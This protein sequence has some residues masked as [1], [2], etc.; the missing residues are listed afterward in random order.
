MN[1]EKNEP[2]EYID[3]PSNFYLHDDVKTRKRI[4]V[5]G[6]S[7][8]PAIPIEYYKPTAICEKCKSCHSSNEHST[9]CR[10]T[11]LISILDSASTDIIIPTLFVAQFIDITKKIMNTPEYAPIYT[12]LKLLQKAYPMFN[13]FNIL[14]ICKDTAGIGNV[15]KL[16]CQAREG[17][18]G[19]YFDINTVFDGNDL[20]PIMQFDICTYRVIIGGDGSA[21][22]W[23]TSTYV[24]N[25]L[26]AVCSED[27]LYM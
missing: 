25:V 4:F 17:H 6:F 11:Y 13:I 5:C 21:F 19:F 15:I 26:E 12:N 24:R 23:F 10:A 20:R 2:K 14:F 27:G 7:E 8:T 16:Q 18:D 22:A 3:I 1:F 9:H